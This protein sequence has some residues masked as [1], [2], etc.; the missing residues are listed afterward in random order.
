MEVI[1]EPDTQG[2]DKREL[3][4]D[5]TGLVLMA[6]IIVVTKVAAYSPLC[7]ILSLSGL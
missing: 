3:S 5:V 1:Y 7:R 4:K 2:M 6:L